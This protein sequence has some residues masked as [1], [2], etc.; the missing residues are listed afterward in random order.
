MSIKVEEKPVLEPEAG[1]ELHAIP[2]GLNIPRLFTKSTLN[3]FAQTKFV[4]RSSIIANPDGSV[5]FRMED[6]EIPEGWS[7]LATD[8]LVSKYFR[9]RGVPG[10]GYE[11]SIKQVVNRIAEAIRCAG[12]ELGSYFAT[13]E[14]A[15]NFEDELKFLLMHQYGAFNSPV[16]FNVGLYSAYGIEGSGG[17]WHWNPQT[18]SVEETKGAYR[19]PQGSACFIQSVSDDLMAIFE[20]AKS[21]ARL[22]KHGSGTG[23]NFS[24]IRGKQEKLSGGGTSSGLMSFLEVL[25]RGAGATKSG[26]TTRRAAKMV[27]LDMDHPEITDFIEWKAK[28]EKKVQVLIAAGFDSD[29]NG[30]AYRTVAGQ[31]SNNSVRMNDDFMYSYLNDGEWKTTYRTTG[32]VCD[33]FKSRELMRKVAAA[34]WTCADPGVQFD[35]TINKW[36]TS[37]NSGKINASNPCSEFVF[38]DDTSC[39]L[40]SLNLMKFYDE[41]SS[42]FDVEKFRAAARVFTAAQE[43]LVDF[44]S[45]PTKTISQNSHD[46]RPLGLG[47]ANLGTL[48]MV[49]GLGYDSDPARNI[50]SAITGILT[51]QAYKTSAEIAAHKGAFP[52]FAKNREA[53]LE[54]M[55]MHR[56]AA[57]GIDGQATPS[58]LR[59]AAIEDW[60]RCLEL[61][62]K[63]G[64]RNAQASVLAPT[65]CLVGNS[66]VT[67]DRGLVRLQTLG[68]PKGS[69]WQDVSFK[70]FTEEGPKEAT[71]FF[72][73]GAA[74]T[75]RIRTKCGY[76]IQGTL[77]HQ[78]RVV[79][80]KTK[81]WVWKRFNEIGTGDIVPLACDQLVGESQKV[82]LPPLGDLH[83]NAE[84]ETVVPREMNAALAELVGYFMGDGSLHAKGLRFCVTEGDLDVIDRL[85][86][87][88]KELFH[89]EPAINKRKGY[90]EVA[91]HSVPLVMWWEACGFS[92]IRPERHVGKGLTPHIPDSILYANDREIY[93]A[94]LRG[95]FEADGCVNA[96]IPNWSTSSKSFSDE[97]KSLLLTI[98]FPTVTK[99]DQSQWGQSTL[100][101]LRLRNQSYHAAFLEE[102]G[103]VSKRKTLL[104]KTEFV[105]PA[106]KDMIYLQEEV[107]KMAVGDS[108]SVH[109]D[110][111]QLS[112]KRH[113][114]VARHRALMLYD[115]THDPRI[116]EALGFFYDMVEVNEDG[117]EEL[118]YDLSVPANVT[119]TANGFLS[120][121]TIG[122]L[123]DCDTTGIEPDFALVKFKKL[124]GGGY[125][126][127]VN[128]SLPKALKKLGYTAAQIADIVTFVVGTG[129][130][131][132]TPHI[133]QE[134]LK[135]KGFN[136]EDLERIEKTLPSVFELSHAFGVHA[137]GKE[138]L[139]RFGF[140]E[141]QYG[142]AGF[143]LLKALGFTEVQIEE[144]SLAICG[145]M[146]VEGAPHLRD[147]HLPV[148]DCA[149][150]CGRSGKR[151]L[152][153]MSHV[154][155]MAAAQPFISG[156]ISKTI[157]IPNEAT[158]EDI[159][160]LYVESWRLGLKAVALYRDGCKMS[161]PLNTISDGKKRE[162][163]TVLPD[164][165]PVPQPV[166]KRRRLPKKRRGMTIEARVGGQK[167][168]LRTGEYED[169]GLGE[170]FIDMHKEGASF[171]SMM[172]CFAIAVS[173]GLQ[174]GV[175]L[176]EF[177]NCFTFTRFEPHGPVD[178][179]NIKMAT[180]V[181]DYIFRVLGMEYEGRT[182]FVQVKP[183]KDEDV[184]MEIEN[185]PSAVSRQLSAKAVEE[186]KPVVHLIEK[187]AL[188]PQSSGHGAN[189]HLLGMMGDAP[190]CDS[191]GHV[192][193]RNGSC[194]KC[195]NCGN[196][197]GCS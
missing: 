34:A 112:M 172:N 123:M 138:A 161:Q 88:S 89:L 5:V 93:Q 78:I 16:W 141:E 9:K 48:L 18:D 76:E 38:L 46:Y 191:C 167:V 95:L 195:L 36:H 30:D 2:K 99:L 39:N 137:L 100:Y 162:E 109:Y 27:C 64:Y 128:Q 174:Y 179:P 24:A 71:K 57:Q 140:S 29:F 70:V 54:V 14:D 96:G 143:N 105:Q 68:N 41:A 139:A 40:A 23:T 6:C 43:I 44:C 165:V 81:E 58:Y 117:G 122:L 47:Y 7:Q 171:R 28:E 181:I 83:W 56:N 115:E 113:G 104:V 158:V 126:K 50:C 192:T 170:I 148:F 3:P 91:V 136:E 31:N 107:L 156:A 37:K 168:Y 62:E 133:H 51:G 145:R 144:A 187:K 185:Q 101:V 20:L 61:G 52:G 173:L 103:F 134:S 151:F 33:V 119:Y 120:H 98:G 49:M 15:Q 164:T 154:K 160:K 25:D 175:P 75:R 111:V 42:R 127:I 66:L 135:L 1:V 86:Q 8:I 193:I 190:F 183:S 12:D 102:I 72:I 74:S 142:K 4:Q 129:T 35:T 106:R 45:Y 182:D 196:S 169:G 92:K 166:L 63:F 114:G 69:Q 116:L 124:A 82:V 121:N 118:T 17:N 132:A 189:D 80:T 149:N 19:H 153:P 79:D 55:K 11:T 176:D 90:T 59:E 73:N 26:G 159:E 84:K 131:K 13:V 85:R 130:L 10:P 184:V 186:K 146:T 194:Y 94:F 108:H 32:E 152:A 21:E 125:F 178:H 87:L 53:M 77:K 110:A 147:E 188:A 22:F 155:M 150:K 163:E 177:V 180:S 157:N 197:M 60:N 65:G 67:T 97:V